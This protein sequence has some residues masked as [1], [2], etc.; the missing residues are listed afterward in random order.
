MET[1]VSIFGMHVYLMELH[2]LISQGQIHTGQ[3]T[4]GCD[5]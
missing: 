5:Q 2:I 1:F 4:W 3:I